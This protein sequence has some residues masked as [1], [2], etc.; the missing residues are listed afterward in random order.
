MRVSHLVIPLVFAVTL[1]L[2]AQTDPAAS[3]Y[4]RHQSLVHV[5][6]YAAGG[7]VLGAWGGYM[8]SQIA[9][10]DWTDTTGRAAQRLR[11][12]LGGA[13]LG[14]LAGIFLGTRGTRIVLA[15]PGRPRLPLPT[16][17]PITA[18]QIRNSSARTLAELL[19]ELR[20]RWVRERGT[21]ILL[22]NGSELTARGGVQVY[23][24]GALIGGLEALDKVP[25]DVVTEIQ[26]MDG[27]A[28]ALRYGAAAEEGAI[29]LTTAAGP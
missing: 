14:L 19:R 6:E 4:R 3:P 23:L 22:P 21:Q 24:N 9:R 25:L 10:S 8:T 2:S 1:P 20:P 15:P 5:V 12:S 13:A 29:L 7:M 28:A 16:N 18:E 11:F 17:G 26:F 27:Q